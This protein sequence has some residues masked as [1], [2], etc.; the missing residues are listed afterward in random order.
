MEL[1]TVKEVSELKGCSVRYVQQLAANNKIKAMQ[2]Y[3]NNKP[4]YMIPLSSL[5][6][7]QL[8]TLKQLLKQFKTEQDNS[9]ALIIFERI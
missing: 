2:E 1:L 7:Q 6:I 3:Y 5:P 4:Q 8:K 9:P